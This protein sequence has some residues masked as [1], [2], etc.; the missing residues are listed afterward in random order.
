MSNCPFAFFWQVRCFVTLESDMNSMER[1]LQTLQTTPTEGN[2]AGAGAAITATA[3]GDGA[4]AKERGAELPQRLQR[5]PPIDWKS[6]LP[7]SYDATGAPA[8]VAAAGGAPAAAAAFVEG[9]AASLQVRLTR[10]ADCSTQIAKH[11][12][13]ATMLRLLCR[14]YLSG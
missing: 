6:P 9:A 12:R 10:N 11:K 14:V 1:L 2:K 8:V 5:R 13:C 7:G 4:S 3:S